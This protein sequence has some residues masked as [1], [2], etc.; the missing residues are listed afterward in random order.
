MKTRSIITV[1]LTAVALTAAAQET[2]YH[3]ALRGQ[4]SQYG[5]TNGNN[6][7]TN[8]MTSGMYW[9]RVRNVDDVAITHLSAADSLLQHQEFM[10]H[11]D[12]AFDAFNQQDYYHTLLYGD[13]A[14]STGLQAADLHLYMGIAFEKLGAYKDARQSFRLS[15]RLGYDLGVSA[16]KAFKARDKQRRREEKRRTHK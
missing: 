2:H 8:G 13:S 11:Y 3:R 1:L 5:L 15:A 4:D 9:S 14:L 6:M 16:Y 7:A 12:K 10:R